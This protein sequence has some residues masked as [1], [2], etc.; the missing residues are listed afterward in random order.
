MFAVGV[1]HYRNNS[2]SLQFA[3]NDATSLA[4]ALT[5]QSNGVFSAVKSKTLVNEQ[6]TRASIIDGLHSF[7]ADA[8]AGDTALVALMGHGVVSQGV[9]YF[10]PYPAD[11]TTLPTEGLM[12]TDLAAAVQQVAAKVQRVIVVADTCQADALDFR[13]RSIQPTLTKPSSR[14]VSLV[15][16]L[17]PKM[18]GTYILSSSEESEFSFED[19]NYRLPGEKVGH[20]AFTYA[21]LRGINGEAARGNTVN[22]LDLFSYASDQVPKITGDRQHPV[23]EGHGTNFALARVRSV[24]AQDAQQ[25]AQLVAKA[26]QQQKQG[27]L[28]QAQVTLARASQLNPNNQVGKVLHDEVSDDLALSKDRS[29]RHDLI[30]EAAEMIKHHPP[31][32]VDPWAPRPMVVAFLDFNTLG[33]GPDVGGLHAALIARIEQ[34]LQGSKRIKVVDRHLLDQVLR[35]L[36]LSASDLSDPATRLKVG[37][38]LVARAIGTGNVAFVGGQHYAVNLQLIDTETTEVKVNLSQQGSDP[39]K[40]LPVADTASASLLKQIKEI[41]PLR[42]KIVALDGDRAILDAGSNAGATPNTRMNAVVET[43]IV[44]NGQVLANRMSNVGALQITSEVYEKASV[45]KVLD[46]KGPLSVGMK[47]IESSKNAQ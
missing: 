22:V 40:I 31:L 7:F 19:S 37:Q 11:G 47:V 6:V 45:A 9:F 42:G 41:Y 28:S 17:A 15:V 5:Q 3:D 13:I 12:G 18:P 32:P 24:P 20:G 39:Q 8:S 2:I 43:P 33:G 46:H 38:I 4:D 34:S 1:S 16:A 23:V 25:S 27:E 36:K 30:E 29:E 21:L 10:V 44:I 26:T 35:E 14:G